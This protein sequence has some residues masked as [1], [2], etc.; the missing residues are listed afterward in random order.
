MPERWFTMLPES[1][2][3][4]RGGHVYQEDLPR[5]LA[6]QGRGRVEREGR[7]PGSSLG[8]EEG[9]DRRRRPRGAL[10]LGRVDGRELLLPQ[11]VECD[12]HLLDVGAEALEE[13]VSVEGQQ[14]CLGQAVDGRLVPVFRPGRGED[15]QVAGRR[16]PGQEDL[17]GSVCDR[18]LDLAGREEED[19]VTALRVEAKRVAGCEPDG[20]HSPSEGPERP[21]AE[22]SEHGR[23]LQDPRPQL[24][25]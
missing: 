4:E 19:H 2:V 23:H 8:R 12:R 18:L 11:P 10:D 5:E 20:A 7:R 21:V 16:A 13:S 1:S 3:S 17:A 9:H 22:L 6:G 24:D 25:A 15:D 14:D